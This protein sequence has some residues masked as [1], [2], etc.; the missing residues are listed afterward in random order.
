MWEHE[1]CT[2]AIIPGPPVQFEFAADGVRD[3]V[4]QPQTNAQRVH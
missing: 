1:Y 4:S 2:V 3:P